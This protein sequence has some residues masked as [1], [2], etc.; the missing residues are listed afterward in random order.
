MKIYIVGSIAS[1]KSTLAKQIAK[2]TNV[3]FYGLDNVVH[4]PDKSNP[5]GNSKRS[6]EERDAMFNSIIQKDNWVIE[7]VGRPCF[8]EGFRQA[9][10][11]VLLEIANLV[12]NFRIILRWIKQNLGIEKCIYKPNYNMLK[13][14]LQWSKD[15]DLG[16]DKLKERLYP[17]KDKVVILSNYKDIKSFLN[18]CCNLPTNT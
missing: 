10:K 1:G 7:D 5:W 2:M 15:Y 12:R 11:I 13:C 17:Y 18:F 6:I 9:N 14:M 8:E 3:E 16:K 4:Q